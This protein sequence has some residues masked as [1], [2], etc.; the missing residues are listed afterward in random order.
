VIGVA[1]VVT[2]VGLAPA[3][4]ATPP[5]AA[6]LTVAD[7]GG[8][9][10]TT[11]TPGDAVTSTTTSQVTQTGPQEHTLLN[12]WDSSRL[13]LS[14][15]PTRPD[16]WPLDYTT[17]GGTTWSPTPP[18]DLSTVNGVR[19]HGSLT[20]TAA[21][22]G[23]P[24]GVSHEASQWFTTNASSSF[25]A[26]SSGD[27]WSTF[28]DETRVFNIHHHN[29][30]NS[31]D[32][33]DLADGTV[34]P[35]FPVDLS[36]EGYY[37]NTSSRPDGWV[38]LSNHHLWFPT[39]NDFTGEVGFACLD[40][41][42]PTPGMCATPFVALK[43]DGASQDNPI[44]FA[45]VGSQLYASDSA[46]GELVCL[47]A[48]AD[49][50]AGA[51]CTDQPYA[52]FGS[53]DSSGELLAVGSNVYAYSAGGANTITCF[54]TTT[55]AGCTG[56]T[57]PSVNGTQGTARPFLP[58]PDASGTIVALCLN[59][60][61]GWTY[62]PDL[63]AWSYASGALECV[64]PTDGSSWTPGANL[65][66]AVSANPPG[67]CC[68][69]YF[70]S[71]QTVGTKMFWPVSSND[72]YAVCFDVVTDAVCANW[73]QQVDSI[74]TVRVDPNN[75]LCL[76]TN[77]N[78][79][80]VRSWDVNTGQQAGCGMPPTGDMTAD[81]ASSAATPR[82]GCA[83]GTS[84]LGFHDLTL[85]TPTTGFDSA[86]LSVRDSDGQPVTDW[87]DV[88]FAPGTAVDLS[89]LSIDAVGTSPTFHVTLHNV[90]TWVEAPDLTITYTTG[91]PQLC[92]PL[93]VVA[94]CPT[95]SGQASDSTVAVEAAAI[96]GQT[97]V[98][99]NGG[100][101]TSTEL[102]STL[103]A[104]TYDG[105]SCFGTLEGHA[106]VPGNVPVPGATVQLRDGDTTLA[107][108]QT[109]AEGGYS[110]ALLYPGSYTVAFSDIAQS[111]APATQGTS[112]T[113]SGSAIVDAAYTGPPPPPAAPDLTSA[114]VA[115]TPQYADV[116]VPTGD[117]VTLLD[118][119][120]GPQTTITQSSGT[121]ELDPDT[122]RITFTPTFGFHGPAVAV[123]YRLSDAYEQS[124]VGT[125]TPTVNKPDGPVAPALTSTDVGL[126]PQHADVTIPSE[127]SVTLLDASDGTQTTI[128]QSSGTYELDPDTGRITFTPVFGFHGPAVAVRYRVTDAYEQ[129]AEGTYTPTV[130]PPGGPTAEALTSTGVGTAHQS[131]SVVLPANGTL[132]LLAGNAET[133]SLS[134]ATG[135]YAVLGATI[136]FAPV[137]GFHGTAAG[138]QY[139]VRDAYDEVADAS[140]TPSV[141]PPPAP[142]AH[143][144]T[145]HGVGTAT[146]TV[147]VAGASG[148][149][150]RLL[151][152][153]GH[154]VAT[155][156]KPNQGTYVLT[157]VTITFTPQDGFAG[158]AT[159][160]V[161]R[162]RDAYGQTSDAA[163][164]PT[165]TAPPVRPSVT[166]GQDGLGRVVVTCTVAGTRLDSCSVVLT[167]SYNGRRIVIGRGA[168]TQ[169]QF[170][171]T[172]TPL[173]QHLLHQR[174]S[175]GVQLLA[176][177]KPHG[178]A[179]AHL[180]VNAR[181]RAKTL[182]VPVVH[183]ASGSAVV[184]VHD[185]KALK[186]LRLKLVAAGVSRVTCV[187]HADAQDSAAHNRS[188]GLAR[189]RAVCAILT[190]KLAIRST[191]LS[192]SEA[193]PVASNA[194]AAGRAA[195]RRVTLRL[196]Y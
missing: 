26:S 152:A 174:G 173:G 188:L 191:T 69:T 192:M 160:V 8:A 73:P 29:G 17:D 119:A 130:N 107:T 40:V 164:T 44:D 88:P 70:A 34:C 4:S 179:L 11:A 32:C 177:V 82:L 68:S 99:V 104:T 97:S 71:S 96:T 83:S 39:S 157:G 105:S 147:T 80:V 106:A 55:G 184:P 101:P 113:R 75:P 159:G 16:G 100:P 145:S 43:G 129:S 45:R 168:G 127:G 186:A 133:S 180:T 24:L 84:V 131:V 19:S 146:Q 149:V 46:T 50:G 175:L 102:T 111:T 33:H 161:F 93:Q 27:G 49:S 140:Y 3:A 89:G 155:V 23:Q 128:T 143:P 31:I 124:T 48:A 64:S 59:E 57:P 81:F 142:N 110:F 138:V 171:V 123:R 166:V 52:G 66:A 13:A 176:S 150:V 196:T 151:G 54:D 115:V 7:A 56:W 14:G 12:T 190:R 158:V 154:E 163:Y 9:A 165:V 21:G 95:G 67:T 141:T 194:T 169:G 134:D 170:F 125:Y 114:G 61:A 112:I 72:T 92:V 25:N 1:L 156:T 108:T 78:D 15:V 87:T 79:G 86:T 135:H 139:R 109:D 37:F 94:P 153:T 181:L 28:F 91:Q 22:S 53:T 167:A 98:S 76:F 51:P 77:G 5:A 183:F 136:T 42:G 62:D 47:D 172:L 10:A 185:V 38:D 41:S 182:R 118:A 58:V 117:S 63:D 103:A 122:G 189:A 162:L 148:A 195:N 178:A 74:Y 30:P 6:S 35:G 121:Y 18:S 60:G 36:G 193:D 120:D 187:G 126:T 20:A 144:L 90:T 132:H 137:V 85:N 116:T 65:V 2:A